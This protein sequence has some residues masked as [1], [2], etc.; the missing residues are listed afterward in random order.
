M[1]LKSWKAKRA[2]GR[3]TVTGVDTTSGQPVKIVGIDT[4][5]AGK[6]VVAV[7]KD[8]NRHELV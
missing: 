7:D 6:P 2:G 3:I 8:G 1:K 5:E 4:I